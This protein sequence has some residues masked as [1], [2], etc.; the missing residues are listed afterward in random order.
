[1]IKL[2]TLIAYNK[3]KRHKAFEDFDYVV[4]IGEKC[5]HSVC[6]TN[7]ETYTNDKQSIDI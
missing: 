3:N 1:M 7:I 4:A 2:S 5:F 6:N